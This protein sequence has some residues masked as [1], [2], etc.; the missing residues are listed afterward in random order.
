MRTVFCDYRIFRNSGTG[1]RGFETIVAHAEIVAHVPL[2]SS[3]LWVIFP[4]FEAK[5]AQFAC[6]P[7]IFDDILSMFSTF[8]EEK[9]MKRSDYRQF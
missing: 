4:S 1:S 3:H 9:L 2:F 6:W 8:E 7:F 5:L